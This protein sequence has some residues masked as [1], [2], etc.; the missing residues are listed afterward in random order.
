MERSPVTLLEETPLTQILDVFS[1]HDFL[2]YPVG[3]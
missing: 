1:Q 3:G 2:C